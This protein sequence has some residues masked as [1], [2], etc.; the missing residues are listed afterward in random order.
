MG[1]A[2]NA[3][4]SA[5]LAVV[6]IKV[7]AEDTVFHLQLQC[8]SRKSTE[9]KTLELSSFPCSNL[10]LKKA[11]EAKFSI[12]VCVQSLSYQL[13]PLTDSDNLVEKRL[14][15]GDSLSVSYLCEGD[16]KLIR[17]I[18][19]W[20]QEILDAVQSTEASSAS[21]LGSV[22]LRGSETGYRKTSIQLFDWLDPKCYVNKLY[23]E[24]EGGLKMLINVYREVANCKWSTMGPVR[25]YLESFSIQ[26]I[27]NFGQTFP[28]RRIT[29]KEGVLD[30]MLMSLLRNELKQGEPIKT[31]DE[32]EGLVWKEVLISAVYAVSK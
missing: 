11:I 3:D 5:K 28:L 2:L 21:T 29:L 13:A 24:A 30:L 12:P 19:E 23:F 32:Y 15:S 31:S 7:M 10:E 18:I 16:C 1:G 4:D 8:T 25:K 22:V 26:T 14:R 20:I 27:G 9:S 6:D 17:D